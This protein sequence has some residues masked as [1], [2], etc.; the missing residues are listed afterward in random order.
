MVLWLLGISGAGKTTLGL[1]LREYFEAK[2]KAC[3]LLDGDEVRNLFESD[4]GYSKE[5][6]EANIKRI[7]LVA[8]VLD[9][10]GIHTTIVYIFL[11]SRN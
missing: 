6:R 8:Y 10:C 2:S 9:K 5:E 1:K 4:L 3:F 7:I 11:P